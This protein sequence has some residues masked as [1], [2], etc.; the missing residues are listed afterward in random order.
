[1]ASGFD[2]SQYERR[3][4]IIFGTLPAWA[5]VRNGSNADIALMAETAGKQPLSRYLKVDRPSQLSLAYPKS[6]IELS[7]HTAPLVLTNVNPLRSLS[8]ICPNAFDLVLLA[9]FKADQLISRLR[10]CQDQLVDL[11]LQRRSVAVLRGLQDG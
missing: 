11:S 7:S 6:G 1:M 2:P 9:I 4:I 5:N 8:L 10:I 3:N